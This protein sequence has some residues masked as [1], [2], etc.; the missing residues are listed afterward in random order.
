MNYNLE[1]EKILKSIGGS[2]PKLLLHACCAPCSSSVLLKIARYFDITILFYNPNIT[3]YDE[4]LKRKKELEGFL[5]MANY[6]IK[7]LDCNYDVEK[8]IDMAY[9]LKDLKEGSVR[10]YKCYLMRLTET[11]KMAKK[12]NFDYF[13]TTLSVSPYKNSKWLNEI[14]KS[15]ED[16][17]QVKYLYSDFKKKDGYKK[18]IELSLKY[19][20]Y[21][22]DYC[23]C[24][25]SKIESDKKKL[26][27]C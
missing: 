1:C 10:C 4:Y 6:N 22:Q 27:A 18:S 3:D 20:L 24:V 23:G 13:T 16:E 14:G 2:K 12:Y 15:L 5:S 25:Y 17:Y 26:K 7:L 21:R 8:F 11:A 9:P 19:H